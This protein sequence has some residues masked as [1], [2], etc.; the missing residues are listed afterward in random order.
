MLKVV[1]IGILLVLWWI[2]VWGIVETLIHL[3][4]KGSA[5]KALFIY[6]SLL[7]IVLAILYTNPSLTKS[8][9]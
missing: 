1:S 7:T 4:A 3:Y 5:K 6:G 9:L 2:A 8:V